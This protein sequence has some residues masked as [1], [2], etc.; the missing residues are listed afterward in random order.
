M[1]FLIMKETDFFI[2]KRTKKRWKLKNKTNVLKGRVG[3]KRGKKIVAKKIIIIISNNSFRK[4]KERKE[5]MHMFIVF[6]FQAVLVFFF[7]HLCICLFRRHTFFSSRF[8]FFRIQT[9]EKKNIYIYILSLFIDVY[10]NYLFIYLFT[11][12]RSSKSKNGLKPFNN[13]DPRADVQKKVSPSSRNDDDDVLTCTKKMCPGT[14][15]RIPLWKSSELT[16]SQPYRRRSS[17]VVAHRLYRWSYDVTT[18]NFQKLSGPRSS[19]ISQKGNLENHEFQRIDLFFRSSFSNSLR[20]TFLYLYRYVDSSPV[21]QCRSFTTIFVS[22]TCPAPSRPFFCLAA[23]S[24]RGR[25]SSLVTSLPRMDDN[26]CCRWDSLLWQQRWRFA[27][28]GWLWEE[29]SKDSF[30]FI[31]WIGYKDTHIPS[32]WKKEEEWNKI[33]FEISHLP[34][35]QN[36]PLCKK[37]EE[38]FLK[39]HGM[40]LSRINPYDNK[41]KVKYRW[42]LGKSFCCDPTPSCSVDLHRRWKD[43]RLEG[44]YFARTYSKTSS[45][46]DGWIPAIDPSS[47]SSCNDCQVGNKNTPKMSHFFAL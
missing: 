30:W 12:R 26:F 28:F 3:F 31:F 38:F 27:S 29:R 24:F 40:E 21:G 46:R 11:L 5:I 18:I 37:K 36:P 23:V 39:D 44:N 6:T 22:V 10:G 45:S 43:W 14:C 35:I 4:K 17:V 32:G 25:S 47:W 1:H 15:S 16:R 13:I 8:T 34:W 33:L 42:L 2:D 20:S 41:K 9:G 19:L 7:L